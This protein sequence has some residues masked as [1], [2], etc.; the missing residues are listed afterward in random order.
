MDAVQIFLE[1]TRIFRENWYLLTYLF[2]L[3]FSIAGW[4]SLGMEGLSLDWDVRLILSFLG[5]LLGAVLLGFS[6]YLLKIRPTPVLGLVVVLL[7]LLVNLLINRNFTPL[8]SLPLVGM[9][10]FFLFLLLIRL[11]F[12][13]GLVVPL[14]ADSVTHVQ[15]VRDML[16]PTAPHTA[17][18]GFTFNPQNYYHIGFHALTGWLS[19]VA[20]VSPEQT[21]LILGQYLQ[22]MAVLGIFPIARFVFGDRLSSWSV[23]LIAALWLPVPAYASNW[24][25]YPAVASLTAISYSF[26]LILLWKRRG[27]GIGTRYVLILA[28]GLFAS[29]LLHTRSIFILAFAALTVFS[30]SWIKNF[31]TNYLEQEHRELKS[32]DFIIPLLFILFFLFV[33][34][35]E[36]PGFPVPMLFMSTFLVLVGLA[37]IHH[38]IKTS[39]MMLFLLAMGLMIV[40]PLEWLTTS[41]RFGSILDRPYL[42]ILFFIPASLL[43]WLGLEGLRKELSEFGFPIPRSALFLVILVFGLYSI[44]S[45][46]DLRP[47]SCCTFVDDDDLFSY[48]WLA[49]N[50]PPASVVGIAAIGVQGNLQAADGGAWIE[51]FSGISTRK[52]EH[53]IDLKLEHEALCR[54]RL[55]YLYVDNLENSFDEY[56]IKN[57]GALH[58]FSLG[59]VR[60]Y[61]LDCP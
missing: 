37:F 12:T 51:H 17:L 9:A 15:I 57:S 6:A 23:M 43:I 22:V 46:I 20:S 18:F 7:I 49:N 41:S 16:D 26:S 38:A 13:A 19:G 3:Q 53:S 34:L 40:F 59:D 25:K 2:M 47:A 35:L 4:F 55:T 31:L 1:G 48:A 32:W 27:V 36:V 8:P 28:I 30:Y 44:G 11:A 50:I 54:S 39:V 14:Y 61:K 52:L 56:E 45:W 60:V 58:Q 10:L 21:I 29:V 33:E 24:G 5:G 42:V